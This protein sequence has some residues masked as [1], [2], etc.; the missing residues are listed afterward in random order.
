M[1]L[2]ADEKGPWDDRELAATRQERRDTVDAARMTPG[3]HCLEG[4][5]TR[6]IIDKQVVL[7]SGV[8]GLD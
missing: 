5:V 8:G 4:K 3:K 1:E 6:A 2:H 7:K